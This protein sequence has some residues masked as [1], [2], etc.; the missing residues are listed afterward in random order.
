MFCRFRRSILDLSDIF[1]KTNFLYKKRTFGWFRK[2]KKEGRQFIWPVVH[3]SQLLVVCIQGRREGAGS[4]RYHASPS[5]MAAPSTPTRGNGVVQTTSKAG[6]PRTPSANRLAVAE[7]GVGAR[8]ERGETAPVD[9]H[10]QQSAR[11]WRSGGD[12]KIMFDNRGVWFVGGRGKRL[13]VSCENLLCLTI[14]VQ[15]AFFLQETPSIPRWVWWPS[16]LTTAVVRSVL[17][18]LVR[19]PAACLCVVDVVV[20]LELYPAVQSRAQEMCVENAATPVV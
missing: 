12:R 3:T 14:I 9:P 8:V 6:G 7:R 5:E 20:P 19:V 10:F 17:P 11:A 1:P 13:H 15:P 18:L 16:C 2:K 4:K